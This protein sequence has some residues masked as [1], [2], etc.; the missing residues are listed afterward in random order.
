MI[1][2]WLN[3]WRLPIP[4]GWVRIVWL[5]LLTS[6]FYS[7]FEAALFEGFGVF[8]MAFQKC[9]YCSKDVRFPARQIRPH[10]S[11]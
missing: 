1:L 10:A 9:P 2:V 4:T 5:K 3:F 6:A 11:R 8:R 7:I